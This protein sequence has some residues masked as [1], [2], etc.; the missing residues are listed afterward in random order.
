MNALE[1][2]GL[3]G[4]KNFK[5]ELEICFQAKKDYNIQNCGRARFRKNLKEKPT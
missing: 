5:I 3:N 2:A 1:R 4:S